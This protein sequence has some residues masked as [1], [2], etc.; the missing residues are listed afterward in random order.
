MRA[1]LQRV[2]LLRP[3]AAAAADALL[4]ISHCGLAAAPCSLNGV[5][6]AG[7]RC[8]CDAGWTG[9]TCATL[10][11]LPVSRGGGFHA[12]GMTSGAPDAAT[13]SWGGAVEQQPDGRWGMVS[14]ELVEHCGIDSWTRNS[15]VVFATSSS[16]P[17]GPYLHNRTLFGPFAHEP[18]L[19][20]APNGSWVLYFEQYRKDCAGARPPCVCAAG[21]GTAKN[22]STDRACPHV[23][24][25]TTAVSLGGPWQAPREVSLLDCNRTF[26]QH[27]MVLAG[28]ILPDNSFLGLVKVFGGKSNPHSEAHMVNAKHWADT[29]GYVQSPNDESGNIFDPKTSPDGGRVEDPSEPWQVLSQRWCHGGLLPSLCCRVRC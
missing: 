4:H 22:C 12:F 14:S 20:R 25:L 28:R 23:T 8:D 1:V 18:S 7:G 2:L 29:D 27:D 24:W 5:C 9:E 13:S 3:S 10:D 15:R 19:A 11:L 26:C 21:A 17:A 16:G 6:A